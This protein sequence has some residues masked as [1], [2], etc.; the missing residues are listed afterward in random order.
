MALLTITTVGLVLLLGHA[1]QLS[2]G[3]NAFYGTGST[4]RACSR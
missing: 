2:L 4:A 1:G 3:Q